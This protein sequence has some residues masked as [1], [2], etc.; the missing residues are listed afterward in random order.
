MEALMPIYNLNFKC[1]VA[2]TGL[3]LIAA[4]I[5]SITLF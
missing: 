5:N 4:K 3:V 2:L 1:V